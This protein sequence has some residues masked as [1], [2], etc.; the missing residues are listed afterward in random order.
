MHLRMIA[1]KWLLEE[2]PSTRRVYEGDFS[3]EEWYALNQQGFNVFYL[4]NHPSEYKKGQTVDGS[5]VDVFNHVFVD[6]DCKS[7]TCPSKEAFMEHVVSL[8]SPPTSIV[9]SGGGIHAYWRVSDL[10]AHSYLRLSRRLMRLLNTDE[11]VGQLYQLMRLPGSVNVKEKE[12]PR[13]CEE[14]MSLE[15]SYTCEELDATLP[16]IT[17]ADEDYCKQHYDKTHR[18]RSE[19]AVDDKIPLKFTKLLRDNSEVKDIWSGNVEDRSAA[20]FRL[21]HLMYAAGF[22]KEEAMSVLVNCDKAKGRAPVHRV[23][24]A[25]NIV[26]KAWAN[27]PPKLE[28]Q[29]PLS[30][31]VEDILA[32]SDDEALDGTRFPCHPVIDNTVCGFRLGH[33]IGLVG[34]SGA[35]K[36]TMALNMFRWFVERNPEYDH[37]FISLEQPNREIASRW[38][39]LCGEDKRLHSKVHIVGNYNK[40]GTF[41][42]LSLAEIKDYVMAFKA[43]T[44]RKIGTVVIDHIGALKMKTKDGQ[45]QGLIDV[46][47]QMKPFALE[48]DT[49]V[50]M[51]SQAPREKAGDGDLEL[52]KDAAYGT[53]FFESY[54]DALLTIW[55]PVKKQYASGA[56]TVLAYKYCKI[57][58]K[59]QGF[60]KIQEDVRYCLLLDPQ[61]EQLRELNQLEEKRLAWFIVKE[62]ARRKE[63]RKL[64]LIEYVSLK[65]KDV[66]VKHSDNQDPEGT[67][68]ASG[69]H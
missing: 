40:D 1:A 33:I 46:C 5:Q 38:K 60:D 44:G 21:G 15:G 48:T 2:N 43:R 58:H 19:V 24:Y 12:N 65:T 32:S 29:E 13:L 39:T 63:D 27:E 50:I 69:L 54:V 49:M 22:S 28:D 45:N 61:T 41:R 10:D 8:A 3:K 57:R 20:D 17:Q 52:G 18:V 26:E 35:G 6:Y 25:E 37:M 23:S 67:K 34:G 62:I 9:D 59:K 4:P 56:P 30:E 14:L 7:G 66:D 42:H 68:S 36:T 55:Q 16:P 31:S 64:Q 51:Q 53:V 11:A 47:H